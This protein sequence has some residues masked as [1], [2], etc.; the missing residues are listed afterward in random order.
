MSRTR[1]IHDMGIQR[2]KFSKEF[3]IQII[4]EIEN[5][6]SVAQISRQH[7]I[8]ES[9]IHKWRKQYQQNPANAFSGNGKISSQE[10]RIAQLER[11]LGKLYLEKEFLKKTVEHLEML[12]SQKS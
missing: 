12:R 5:G 3:K 8:Q 4:H 6:T 9:M 1:R 7:E 10:A 2:R 11:I